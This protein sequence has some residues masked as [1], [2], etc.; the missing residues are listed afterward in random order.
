MVFAHVTIAQPPAAPQP[1]D[2]PVYVPTLNFDVASVRETQQPQDSPSWQMGLTSALHSSE[3]QANGITPKVLVQAA[4]GFGAYEVSGAPDWFESSFWAVEAKCDH[5]VDEQL[6][7]LTD[8]QA[9]LEKQHM[10]QALLAERFHLKVHWETKQANVYALT[11]AKGGSK[12]QAD[13]VEAPDPSIPN[14]MPPET[15]GANI[16]AHG[17]PQGRELTATHI[18]AKG[19]AALLSAMIRG[20]VEDRTGLA[21]RYNFTLR[22]TYQSSDPESYPS[23]FTA[24]REQLGLQ[25]ERTRGS[26]DVLVIDHMDRPTAN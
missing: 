9:R 2:P 13:K 16:Q 18:T 23:I 20:N 4:Y 25:L 3:F 10:M 12:L 19:I 21:D 8:D 5:S 14:S 24:V 26:I 7:K 22:Y 15:R 6:A 17:V 11:V 1:G